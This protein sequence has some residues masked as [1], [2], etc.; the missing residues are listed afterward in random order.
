MVRGCVDGVQ[1]ADQGVGH[2]CGQ[3]SMEEREKGDRSVEKTSPRRTVLVLLSCWVFILL[4]IIFSTAIERYPIEICMNLDA[5]KIKGAGQHIAQGLLAFLDLIYH[6]LPWRCFLGFCCLG[7]S[8]LRKLLMDVDCRHWLPRLLLS[9]YT[10]TGQSIYLLS[11][12]RL[13][14]HPSTAHYHFARLLL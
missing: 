13:V 4:G 5:L 7:P 1:R 3:A 14:F 2:A 9:R 8:P 12:W 11:T 10:H 6:S